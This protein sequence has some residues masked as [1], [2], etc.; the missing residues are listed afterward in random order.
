MKVVILAGGM[1]TRLGEE[2]SLRP[3]PLIEVGEY[4]ILWHIMQY[5]SSFGHNEFI[6]CLGYKGHMIK[7]FFTT[8]M[9]HYSDL[10]IDLSND[11]I[12][13]DY[14]K[15]EKEQWKIH[16]LHTGDTNMTGSRIKQI[17]SYIG[18]D[19]SFLLTYGDGLCNAD[20][21]AQ[22]K[23]H[24]EHG[25]TVTM[26]AIQPPGR[27]GAIN[28]NGDQI[29][30]FQEKPAGDGMYINGGFF[31]CNKDIFSYLNNNADLVFEQ[32]PLQNLANDGQ[33]MGF[34]HE[35]F[36]QCMDTLR[37]KKYL[38]ELWKSGKAPWKR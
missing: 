36:W 5:Y 11:S 9:S 29:T 24:K 32:T 21:N 20:F 38:D 1:G 15:H 34:K 7:D 33:L 22:L 30:S 18:D 12:Q 17:Q 19:E 23:F 6:V 2:T 25:K 28:F 8:Y 10:T 13:Y 26:L 31:I 14:S 35:G 4:P 16:L 37:D 27:F 3:K